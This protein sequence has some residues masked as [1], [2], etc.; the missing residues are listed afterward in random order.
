MDWFTK[1]YFQQGPP[2]PTPEDRNVQSGWLWLGVI[3][4]SIF[5]AWL[6]FDAQVPVNWY[7]AFIGI[8]WG[9]PALA[10]EYFIRKKSRIAPAV[11]KVPLGCFIMGIIALAALTLILIIHFAFEE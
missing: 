5:W 1:D 11:G 9:L 8:F 7:L 2:D 10:I 3:A 4:I 6:A